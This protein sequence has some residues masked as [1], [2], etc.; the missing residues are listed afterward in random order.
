[1]A[2]V[3]DKARALMAPVLGEQAAN[4]VISRINAIGKRAR[5]PRLRAADA[6][7]RLSSGDITLA[8]RPRR[9]YLHPGCD[10]AVDAAHH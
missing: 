5:P 4:T 2:Q 1:M 9:Q 6:R 3:A 7:R 10:T 8:R